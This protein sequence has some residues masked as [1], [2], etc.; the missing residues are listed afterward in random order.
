MLLSEG[1]RHMMTVL[2]EGTDNFR[3]D[4]QLTEEKADK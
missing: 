4:H 3:L 1:H 2:L